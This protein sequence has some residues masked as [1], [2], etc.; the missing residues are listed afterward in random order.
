[1]GLSTCSSRREKDRFI[2]STGI[3]SSGS[4]FSGYRG[5]L[6]SRYFLNHSCQSG[7]LAP[8]NY[9]RVGKTN[10]AMFLDR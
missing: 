8:G 3:T 4:P 5:A 10:M 9:N 2:P 7:T 6:L 1:M